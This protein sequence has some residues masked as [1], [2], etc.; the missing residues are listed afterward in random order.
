MKDINEIE[1]RLLDGLTDSQQQAVKTLDRNL[2]IIACAGAGKTKTITHR[3]INLIAHGADPGSIVA[4]TF[5]RKAAAEMKGRIY[6][7]GEE[8]LGNT[9]GFASMYIGTID[10]YCFKMLQDLVPEYA[11][12]TVLDEV[13]VKIFLERFSH[14]GTAGDSIGMKGTPLD[15]ASNLYNKPAKK[16]DYY[17]NMMSILNSCYH[18]RNYTRNWDDNIRTRVDRYRNCLMDHKHFDFSLLIREMIQRLDPQSELNGGNMSEFAEQLFG[19]VKYLTVDEYQDS[20]PPQEYLVSLF[21]KYGRTNLCVVGDADQTI[22]QFRGSDESNILSFAAAHDAL[23]IKLNQDF[24]ST[25]AIIDV[26]N[27]SIADNHLNDK[28]HMQMIPGKIRGSSMAYEKGD[29]VWKSFSGFDSEAEFIADRIEK[30]NASGVPLSEIAVLF[31]RRKEY[32]YGVEVVDFQ[33]VLSEKLKARNIDSI[34]EGMN[35]LHLTDE[36]TASRAIFNY[37]LNKFFPERRMKWITIPLTCDI[38]LLSLWTELSGSE[39]EAKA[40]CGDL[41]AFMKKLCDKGAKY[42]HELNMQQIFQDFI[43]HFSFMSDTEKRSETIKYNLGKFSK[44]IAD[45]ELFY[46]KENPSYKLTQF[47]Y[48]LQHVAENLYPEGEQDNAMIRGDA[49]RLMTVHQSKGMEFTAVFI[50]ALCN[51]IFPGGQFPAYGGKIYGITDLFDLMNGANWFPNRNIYNTTIEGERKLFYVAVT[52]AKKYLFLTYSIAYGEKAEYRSVFLDEVCRSKF[53]EEYEE[54]RNYSAEHLPSMREEPLPMVL[55]FSLLSNYFDCPYRFKLS[56]FYGFVQPYSSVQG[57]GTMLHEI[58]MHIHRAWID[59][60]KLNSGELER[61]AEDALYLPFANTKELEKA[62]KGAKDCAKAYVRQNEADADKMVASEMDINIEMGDGVSVNGRID[63]VRKVDDDGSEK[64]AIIDL[65][66]AGKDAEQ[67]LNAEQ[68]KI[69]AI[70]YQEATGE[71]ADYLMIYN[72]DYPDGKK[73]AKEE[74]RR[75]TLVETRKLVLDAARCIRGDHLPRQKG[76]N[77]KNCY[78]KHLCGKK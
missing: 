11:K 29:I 50:P 63:L 69:Y 53:I 38:P 19:R 77:C 59:G 42:G 54:M 15:T 6:K 57:Y 67:C 49:V 78:V 9:K 62:L 74:V 36:Y 47:I 32:N 12:F 17:I 72:L 14:D 45:F 66:S 4:I 8:I 52:R 10:A 70:G 18:D 20:N 76:G 48:H 5:T 73:N 26:A 24:R 35:L 22:Y 3:I 16:M 51:G 58:M 41:D 61:I 2:E 46:F 64:T 1:A 43:S 71:P 56:N 37:A 21:E 27:Y 7:A 30:L 13:Q 25:D 44:V 39:K 34:V 28:D 33:A 65:K 68:L 60:K 40:A 75:E 23:Q 55:N 31:R